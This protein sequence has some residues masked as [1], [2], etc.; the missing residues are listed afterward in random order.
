MTD[1][2]VRDLEV[3]CLWGFKFSYRSHIHDLE[4]SL[5]RPTYSLLLNKSPG[6]S[7]WLLVTRS[8]KSEKIQK[9]ENA[10]TNAN[11]RR[12][13]KEEKGKIEQKLILS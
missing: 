1:L 9:I 6:M 10:N 7:D 2:S 5:A 3:F 12:F 13:N 8:H 4:K 11:A